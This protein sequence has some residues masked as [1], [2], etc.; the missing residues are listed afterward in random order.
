MKSELD[1]PLTQ[2]QFILFHLEKIKLIYLYL[3][4]F[5]GSIGIF[6]FSWGVFEILLAD[7]SFEDSFITILFGVFSGIFSI[8][9]FISWNNVRKRIEK[10]EEQIENRLLY[11]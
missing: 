3:G 4:F 5:V 11:P 1:K 7:R 10:I 2:G 9:S 6:L 8:G